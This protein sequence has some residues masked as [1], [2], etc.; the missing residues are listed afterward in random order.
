ML[1]HRHQ[2]AYSLLELLSTL[3]IITLLFSTVTP[4]LAAFL[5]Q[6]R[7]T[8]QVNQ[9]IRVIHYARGE[10]ITRRNPV[11]LC[12]GTTLCEKSRAWNGALHVFSDNNG[13]GRLDVG[14]TLLR[15]MDISDE[16]TWH[17]SNFR[18][19]EYLTFQ[20]DGTTH[21]LN[22]T[23]LLCK[24]DHPVYKVVLNLQGR[25]RT[26]PADTSATCQSER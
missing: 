8:S 7:Q 1:L 19:R 15:S 10:A 26:A 11:T 3:A 18:Q 24:E 9:M 2:Q 5:Q 25:V 6:N 21:S 4:S 22:G 14:E 13:N 20:S 12:S 16:Y 23:L 17:W